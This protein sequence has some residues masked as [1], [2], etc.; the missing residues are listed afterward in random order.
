M[1]AYFVHTLTLGAIYVIV[2]LSYAI[3]VGYTGILNLGHVGLLA[4]GAYT[5]AILVTKGISFWL[6]LPAAGALAGILGFLLAL[7]SRQI[8]GDYYALMTLGFTF[9]VNTVLLN[10][11]SL[12]RGPFGIWGI[13]RPEGFTA[14]LGFL[15]L[16]LIFL[17]VI[18]FL[19]YRII[20]SPF[21][22]A[23]EAVRDDELV[24]ESLGK[25]TGKLKIAALTI[26]A[27][28]VGIGGA[29]LGSFLMFIN[30]QVFWLD[31]AVLIL[32]MLVV[33]GLA[34]FQ[35]AILGTIVLFIFLEGARFLPFSP[36]L[37]GAL[38]LM[39]LALLI[40]LVVLFKPKGIL[41]RAQ[42]E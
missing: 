14:P 18:A 24:A 30:P 5:S 26:S 32:A 21:G 23:L 16:S 33:G 20:H 6:A 7:P 17:I 22:R 36:D 2:S 11:Q 1:F 29:L 13:E 25:P 28:I 10:W 27:V 12:T 3:A 37:V 40:L 8:K 4:I 41:G 19:V 35:G 39:V 31:T 38:R 42:L 15:S 9:V 34:S